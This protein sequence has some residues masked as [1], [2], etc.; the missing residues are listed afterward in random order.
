MAKKTSAEVEGKAA[1]KEPAAKKKAVKE[2]Q[3]EQTSAR[4][5]RK[6]LVT[7]ITASIKDKKAV[8]GSRQT[9]RLIKRDGVS[10]VIYS[11]NTPEELVKDLSYYA[12]L[13]KVML[14]QFD[15]DSRALGEL[16]GKPF[17]ILVVGIAK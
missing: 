11:A 13:S 4:R 16:C 1:K 6:Q 8:L 2:T 5:S 3:A 15:G 7:L 17:N 9:I 12:K 14:T 10:E